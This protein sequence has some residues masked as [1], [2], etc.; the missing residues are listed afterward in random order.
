VSE[1]EI[2]ELMAKAQRSIAAAERLLAAGDADFAV[3]RAYYGMFYAARALLLRRDVRRSKHSGVLAA[4]GEEFVRSGPISPDLFALLRDGFEDRA[5]G[6]YGLVEISSDQAE[7]S[8]D[9]ARRFVG[10][11]GRHLEGISRTGS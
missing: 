7:A 2:R 9:G 5:E 4:F 6:D 10:E 8:I 3:S 11:I 1:R